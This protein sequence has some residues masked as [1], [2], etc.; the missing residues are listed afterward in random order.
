MKQSDY[1][2]M[3]ERQLM[4]RRVRVLRPLTNAWGTI[5]VGAECRITRKF[6]GFSLTSDPCSHC[7]VRVSMSRVNPYNVDLLPG[8]MVE[9]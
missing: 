9:P 2:R 6:Q 8:P 1:K 7:G 5:P 3:T 4:G